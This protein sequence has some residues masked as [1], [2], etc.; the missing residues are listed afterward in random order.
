MSGPTVK[1]VKVGRG[2][3]ASCDCRELDAKNRDLSSLM[4]LVDG[5]CARR[6]PAGSVVE[7]GGTVDTVAGAA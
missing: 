7:L 2:Y 3:R 6:H 1:V 4:R 5:H